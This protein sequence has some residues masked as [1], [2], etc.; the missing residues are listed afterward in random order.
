MEDVEPLIVGGF[1]LTDIPEFNHLLT[2]KNY[3][4]PRNLD[5]PMLPGAGNEPAMQQQPGGM[6]EEETDLKKLYGRQ[7]EEIKAMGFDDE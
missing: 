4:M 1:D 2:K 6:R 7:L 3:A 5:L